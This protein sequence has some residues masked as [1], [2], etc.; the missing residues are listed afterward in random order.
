MQHLFTINIITLQFCCSS[1]VSKLWSTISSI[2]YEKPFVIHGINEGEY[3]DMTTTYTVDVKI[4][5][6]IINGVV[7]VVSLIYPFVIQVVIFNLPSIMIIIREPVVILNLYYNKIGTMDMIST[8]NKK[9]SSRCS[10]Y[11]KLR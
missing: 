8:A 10:N 6:N 2:S 9:K 1:V 11:G 3:I 4:A 7:V 5:R